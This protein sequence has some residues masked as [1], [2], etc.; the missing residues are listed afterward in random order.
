MKTLSILVMS[1]LLLAGS[2]V[3]AAEPVK[4]PAK[5]AAKETA[6][7]RLDTKTKNL[8]ATLDD[9]Q[10]RQLQ[11]IRNSHGTIRAVENVQASVRSAV[12]ACGEK[13]PDL[14][15]PISDRFN[16]WRMALRPTMKKAE[17]RLEKMI[18]LQS[19]GKPSEIR[20]YLKLFDDAAAQSTAGIKTVPITE[21]AECEQLMKTMDKTQVNLNKLLVEQLGLD[22]D[23]KHK[24]L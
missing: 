11:A 13:N 16:D 14:K 22:Q 10:T 9:N 18:L 7:S 12:T 23:L 5:E 20:A 19:I 24:D 2:P 4:E 21:K 3:S 1:C 15:A 6:Q 8:M 17:D